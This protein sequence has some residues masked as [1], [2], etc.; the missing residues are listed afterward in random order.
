[1][2]ETSRIIQRLLRTNAIKFRQSVVV[3]KQSLI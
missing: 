1:M 3:G 2:S